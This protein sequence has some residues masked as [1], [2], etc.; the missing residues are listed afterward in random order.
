MSDSNVL[1]HDN[2]FIFN[3]AEW[4][5]RLLPRAK[6]DMHESNAGHDGRLPITLGA[7]E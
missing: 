4:C 6:A 5:C 7:L 2:N 3:S 1:P